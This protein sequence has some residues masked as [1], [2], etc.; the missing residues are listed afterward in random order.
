M[1][2]QS[3]PPC[4]GRRTLSAAPWSITSFN[5]R[6]RAG[7]DGQGLGALERLLVSIHAPVRG[8]TLLGAKL[9]KWIAVSIHAPVRGATF[10]GGQLFA[11]L[12]V[13][14]HAPVRGATRFAS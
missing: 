1:L 2:F 6:P 10:Y 11:P 4:G 14:I 8:A 5:P 13:S 3:T 9:K 12:Y 7:G